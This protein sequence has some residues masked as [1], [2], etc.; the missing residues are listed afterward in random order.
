MNMHAA[1]PSAQASGA[2]LMTPQ[3]FAA[4][5]LEQAGGDITKATI[6]GMGKAPPRLLAEFAQIGLR[7]TIGEVPRRE[8]SILESERRSRPNAPFAMNAATRAAQDRVRTVGATF[9]N[10]T[11]NQ[12]YTIDGKVRPLREWLGTDIL[13]H[14]ERELAKGT[15]AVRNARFAIAVG[16]AAGSRVI[17]D[18]LKDK[19]VER[20][21]ADADRN[22]V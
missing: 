11:L 16:T 17:G 21:R 6:I 1:F 2:K 10:A 20:M 3:T 18:A 13:A 5:M 22:P 15:T 9:A 7:Q 19:D 14:G 4:Q 12:P 8:R